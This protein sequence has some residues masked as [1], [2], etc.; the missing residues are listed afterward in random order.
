MRSPVPAQGFLLGGDRRRLSGEGHP[1]SDG[2]SDWGEVSATS[3][4]SNTSNN[5][6]QHNNKRTKPR[7][8][9]GFMLEHLQT[10]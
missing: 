8:K 1:Q 6:C 9:S 4:T 2:P 3:Y 5:L 10:Q 7:F